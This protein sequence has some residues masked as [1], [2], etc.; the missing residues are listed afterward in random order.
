MRRLGR[1]RRLLLLCGGRRRAAPFLLLRDLLARLL[2]LLLRLLR[3]EGG[4]LTLLLLLRLGL[5][6]LCGPGLLCLTLR[7]DGCVA[8]VRLLGGTLEPLLR[9]LLDGVRKEERE[10]LQEIGVVR[11]Q[12]RDLLQDFFDAAL[13][14]LVSVKDLKESL[15]GAG[16]IGEAFLDGRDVGD[17]VVEFNHSSCVAPAAATARCGLPLLGLPRLWLHRRLANRTTRLLVRMTRRGLLPHGTAKLLLRPL[18]CGLL[19]LLLLLVRR[20]RRRRT[21]ALLLGYDAVGGLTQ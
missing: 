3:L 5:G 21:L 1:R 9:L 12:G 2:L 6:L 14:L 17:G 7:L 11:E 13:L 20:A 8:R 10:L 18:H 15:V 4:H 19:Q 16:V